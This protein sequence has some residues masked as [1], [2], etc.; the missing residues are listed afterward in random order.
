M[1]LASTGRRKTEEL[2]ARFAAEHEQEEDEALAA[3]EQ[4]EDD[5]SEEDPDLEGSSDDSEEESE[6]CEEDETD[7]SEEEEEESDSEE[8]P[9]EGLEDAEDYRW[10]YRCLPE[11]NY[12]GAEQSDS[13]PNSYT[14]SSEEEHGSQQDAS[15]EGS[16]RTEARLSPPAEKRTREHDEQASL[17]RA[18]HAT[19]PQH[20]GIRLPHDQMCR[21]LTV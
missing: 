8:D 4:A 1:S 19:R 20:S 9:H 3:A 2:W 17:S 10:D 7:E 5:D 16:F 14:I 18:T 13:Q 12:S 6:D 11:D 21:Y 15:P